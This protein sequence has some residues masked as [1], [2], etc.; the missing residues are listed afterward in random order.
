VPY[1][2]TEEFKRRYVRLRR[3][4]LRFSREQFINALEE[5]NNFYIPACGV[6]GI[7]F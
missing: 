2:S 7:E 1:R 5:V 6:V 3:T 4:Y